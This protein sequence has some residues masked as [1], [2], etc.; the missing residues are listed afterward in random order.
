MASGWRM[1]DKDLELQQAHTREK[2]ELMR[3]RAQA[4]R[5]E[6]LSFTLIGERLGVG[7]D[8]ARTLCGVGDSPTKKKQH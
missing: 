1:L 4:M 5:T 6:G 2:Q 8:A 7:V 3:R